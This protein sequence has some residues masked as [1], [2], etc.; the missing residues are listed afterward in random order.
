MK[1]SLVNLVPLKEAGMGN[2]ESL[3]RRFK[4]S[5]LQKMLDD[6]FAEQDA[7]AGQTPPGN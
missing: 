3:A 7:Y 1:L 5:Q 2:S 4:L 6:A